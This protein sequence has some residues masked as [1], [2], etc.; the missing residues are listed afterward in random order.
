MLHHACHPQ[1]A[2]EVYTTSRPCPALSIIHG[3][4]FVDDGRSVF[5]IRRISRSVFGVLLRQ[6]IIQPLPPLQPDR[7][8]S[9]AE[10]PEPRA[11]IHLLP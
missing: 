3:D 4:D 2:E 9:D 6:Q 8:D 7:H 10:S 5:L 11:T 1:L